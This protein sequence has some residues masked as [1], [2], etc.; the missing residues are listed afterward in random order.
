MNGLPSMYGA[1]VLEALAADLSASVY[2]ALVRDEVDAG[3]IE[4]D[5]PPRNEPADTE[6]SGIQRP[7]EPAVRSEGASGP[8]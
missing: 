1:H 8:S 3:S 2:E 4:L 6:V 5:P 7:T